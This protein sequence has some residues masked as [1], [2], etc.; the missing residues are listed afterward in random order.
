MLAAVAALFAACSSG[1]DDVAERPNVQNSTTDQVPVAFDTYVSRGTTRAG[2]AGELVTS[3][4]TGTKINLVDHGFG[5]FA[6]YCD[7]VPYSETSIPDFMY[8]QKVSGTTWTYSPVKYWPNEFGQAAIS[9]NQD[10]L[11]FFAYAPWVDVYPGTGRIKTGSETEGIVGLTT[12]TTTGDPYVKYYVSFEPAKSVDLCWGVAETAGTPASID[13]TNAAHS[14]TAGKPYI[15]IFK[16]KTDGKIKFDFKHA[17]AKLNVQIDAEVD[18]ASGSTAGLGATTRIWVRSVT[19]EGFADKG[20]LNLNS[21]WV[22]TNTT[23]DWYEI[24]SA[25]TKIGSRSVTIYDGRSDGKEGKTGAT[26]SNETTLGLN[27]QLIQTAPYKDDPYTALAEG[28]NHTGVPSAGSGAINLFNHA[29]ATEPIFVI[30]AGENVIVTIVYDVETSDE[31]LAK[32]LSDGVVKGSTIENKITQTITF[33]SDAK[34]EAGK[35]YTLK[36]HLGMTTVKFDAIVSDWDDTVADG[37]EDLPE[38]KD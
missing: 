6:Y 25:N 24:S 30:P 36:L 12:N 34:F 14:I 21:N 9:D 28:N 33:G 15:N 7:G 37:E 2:A 31:N 20:K 4:G 13:P 35:A 29:T 10:R 11:T 1:S 5:V 19:F 3:G 22:T 8:N 27:P 18:K 23:P 26:A 17:L 38:N 32:Y 16:P